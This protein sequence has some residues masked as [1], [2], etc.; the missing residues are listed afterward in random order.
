MSFRILS[1]LLDLNEAPTL[2]GV[3]GIVSDIKAGYDSTKARHEKATATAEKARSAAEGKLSKEQTDAIKGLTETFIDEFFDNFPNFGSTRG[4]EHLKQNIHTR[5]Q[6][7]AAFTIFKK[8][9]DELE[10]LLNGMNASLKNSKKMNNK[11]DQYIKDGKR[12][13]ETEPPAELVNFVHAEANFFKRL[14]RINDKFDI[15]EGDFRDLLKRKMDRTDAARFPDAA[16][17]LNILLAY[18]IAEIQGYAKQI[19]IMGRKLPVPT[20]VK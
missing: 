10:K 12:F 18:M 7:L 14:I 9:G 20:E 15:D 1:E 11:L 8:L 4:P 19:A 6:A 16:H 3:K 17:A 13:A 2:A 5:D